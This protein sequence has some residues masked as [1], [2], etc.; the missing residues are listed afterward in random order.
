MDNWNELRTAYKLA[1][2]KTLSAT[3]RELGVHR[4]T[5]MRHIDALEERLQ[6]TL[7]QR[8]DKGYV[9]T[10][11]GN[12]LM[13]LGEVMDDQIRHFAYKAKSRSASLSGKLTLTCV[14]E[15][16][17]LLLPAIS[18]FQH[19]HQNVQ[20]EIKGDIRNFALEYGEA[21]IAIRAGFKPT[22]PDNVVLPLTDIELVL[23][24]HQRYIDHYG[25]PQP[26]NLNSH[27][28]IAMSG[29][30]EHL[31]WNEWLH[32]N[33]ASEQI[34]LRSGTTQVLHHAL[35]HGLGLGFTTRETLE[36]DPHLFEVK[37]DERFHIPVWILVHR[38]MMSSLKV[39]AFL[40]VLRQ[41]E[42]LHLAL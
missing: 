36:A 28:F 19:Q 26:T 21:D 4:S 29:R 3:A 20:I 39:R 14:D 8:S 22:T 40:D 17:R 6:V 25:M 33:V 10:D 15:M 9:A 41:E 24:V 32:R 30:H 18:Q 5:V 42:G 35:C 27:R 34:M 11:V 37:I 31:A 7:F 2:C 38:D 23:V 13:Q 16:V 12:E 1:R